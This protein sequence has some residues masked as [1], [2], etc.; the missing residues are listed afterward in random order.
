MWRQRTTETAF[1]SEQQQQARGT[2]PEPPMRQEDATRAARKPASES[3]GSEKFERQG[4]KPAP[5][6]SAG[7][8][9]GPSEPPQGLPVGG[10]RMETFPAKAARQP[11]TPAVSQ[12][13]SHVLSAHPVVAGGGGGEGR[14]G[15]PGASATHRKPTV[16]WRS[17]DG[18]MSSSLLCVLARTSPEGERSPGKYLQGWGKGGLAAAA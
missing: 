6:A 17:Y 8:A 14:G 4:A 3:A 2:H 9:Q 7:D 10:V 5:H 16:P 15:D 11:R 1:C 18:A 12:K 13:A